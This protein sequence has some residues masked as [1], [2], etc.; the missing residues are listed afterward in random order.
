MTLSFGDYPNLDS[1]LGSIFKH[2]H[3]ATQKPPDRFS[4]K[5]NKQTKKCVYW[6]YIK[7]EIFLDDFESE[8][9]LIW[10]RNPNPDPE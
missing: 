3:P 5:Q 6:S 9:D 1:G 8:P 2:G 10:I 4:F 7:E